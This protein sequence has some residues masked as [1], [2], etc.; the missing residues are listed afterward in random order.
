[1][2]AR[3]RLTLEAGGEV[4][5]ADETGLREFPPLR[6][7]WSRVREQAAVLISGRNG[8]RVVHGALNAA[9]GELVRTVTATS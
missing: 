7:A 9:T 4:W 3:A 5:V 6:C 2:I 1:M 8:R